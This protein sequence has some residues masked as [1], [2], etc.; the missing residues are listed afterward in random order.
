[1]PTQISKAVA[2]AVQSMKKE[3]SELREELIVRKN[4]IYTLVAQIEEL[5]QKLEEQGKTHANAI[6]KQEE[7]VAMSMLN[8][9]GQI[10]ALKDDL[11][12][13][14]EQMKGCGGAKTQAK[15]PAEAS[16]IQVR[17]P[18]PLAV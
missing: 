9:L 18:S 12:G 4:Q 6:S 7:L 8:M 15:A 1:M 11:K 17:A 2:D 10:D 14:Q 13:L 3:V 16:P 5:E